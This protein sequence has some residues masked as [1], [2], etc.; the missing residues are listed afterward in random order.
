MYNFAFGLLLYHFLIWFIPVVF[1]LF[2]VV[3]FVMNVVD[4][5]GFGHNLGVVWHGVTW[6]FRQGTAKR[7]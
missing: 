5:R 2:G 3:P 7:V 6:V 4:G 1:F